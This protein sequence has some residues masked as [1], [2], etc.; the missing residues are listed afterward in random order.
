ML[1]RN[2]KVTKV[3]LITSLILFVEE[4]LL[5]ML[6]K[7]PHQ[8]P[9]NQFV[10]ESNDTWLLLPVDSNSGSASWLSFLLWYCLI[11]KNDEGLHGHSSFALLALQNCSASLNVWILTLAYFLVTWMLLWATLL[12]STSSSSLNYTTLYLY[13]FS[14]NCRECVFSPASVYTSLR[15]RSVAWRRFNVYVNVELTWF[16]SSFNS[17]KCIQKAY[18]SCC[19]AFL[20]SMFFD[21]WC[22][23][24]IVSRS[25]I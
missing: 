22:Y 11:E 7:I 13:L 4:V 21:Y 14:S 10:N 6:Y 24:N 12:R 16:I 8:Y 17:L 18:S 9:S 19:L 25:L 23:W 1:H 3:D 5:L 20:S 15:R 2:P